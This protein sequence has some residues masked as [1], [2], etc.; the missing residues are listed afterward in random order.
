MA[1]NYP[2]CSRPFEAEE[3]RTH[4]VTEHMNS[5]TPEIQEMRAQTAGHLECPVCHRLI[6]TAEE[7]RSHIAAAHR[8]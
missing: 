6:G 8:M 5:V 3:L 4:L 1:P 7:V 2:V